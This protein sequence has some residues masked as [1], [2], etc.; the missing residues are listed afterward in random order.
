MDCGS[1]CP[2][3][4]R[5]VVHVGDKARVSIIRPATDAA[6]A[7]ASAAVAAAEE[8]VPPARPISL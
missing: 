3:D 5:V 4:E 2:R 1:H 8:T 6:D 7:A